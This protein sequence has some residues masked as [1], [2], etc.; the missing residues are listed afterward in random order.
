DEKTGRCEWRPVTLWSK[1][2]DCPVELVELQSGRQIV[3]DD[4]PRAVYGVAA[5][6][7]AL[8]RATPT[9][10]LARKFL[11]PRVVGLELPESDALSEARLVDE[12]DLDGNL[13][14]GSRAQRNHLKDSV[15]ADAGLGYFLGCMAGDGWSSSG[16][17]V[18]LAGVTPE[19]VDKVDRLVGGLYV[20]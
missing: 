15:P 1:H 14:R 11:V 8:A 16:R 20:D 7:L 9:E 6:T 3:T 10:A 19:V 5:G 4:D 13:S 12:V 2:H 17:D 18:C